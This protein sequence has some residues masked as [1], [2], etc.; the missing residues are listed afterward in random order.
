MRISDSVL[1]IFP[2]NIATLGADF[3][4]VNNDIVANFKSIKDKWINL[5]IL[6]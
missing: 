6:W 1:L 3:K 4:I 2:I 5:D